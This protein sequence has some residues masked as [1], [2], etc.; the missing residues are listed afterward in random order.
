MS[1][2]KDLLTEKGYTVLSFANELDIHTQYVYN[3][4]NK[5]TPSSKYIVRICQILDCKV[6]DLINK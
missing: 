6:E 3:W 1:K 4:I 2:L 5:Y